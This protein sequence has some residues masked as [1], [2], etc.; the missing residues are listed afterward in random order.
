MIILQLVLFSFKY[1]NS[2]DPKVIY[3]KFHVCMNVQCLEGSMADDKLTAPQ[4]I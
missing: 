1:M 3:H 4:L 2:V